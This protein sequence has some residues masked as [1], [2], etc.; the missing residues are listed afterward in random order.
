MPKVWVKVKKDH[1]YG[2]S[3]KTGERYQAD[4]H[5]L[6]AIKA[7]NLVEEDK[8]PEVPPTPKKA[9]VTEE[10]QPRSILGIRRVAAKTVAAKKTPRS[11]LT[12]D[13][14]ADT[15]DTTKTGDPDDQ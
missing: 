14:V 1:Y 10:T 13:M 3:R 12:R 4:T 6:P 5:L 11:Y 9:T 2:T 7:L 8:E 15:G